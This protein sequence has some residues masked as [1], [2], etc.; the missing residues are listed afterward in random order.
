MSWNG[1]WLY[2]LGIF[3]LI[4]VSYLLYISGDGSRLRKAEIFLLVLLLFSA[5]PLA[6]PLISMLLA[7]NTFKSKP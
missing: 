5:I 1:D 4:F 2:Q 3:G 7:L 6:F